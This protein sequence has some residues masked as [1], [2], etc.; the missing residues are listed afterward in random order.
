M[1]RVRFDD[2]RAA[3]SQRGCGVAAGRGKGQR[4]ITRAKDSHRTERPQHRPQAGTGL[5]LA[6][7]Q[8]G[9]NAR[10]H[11][12]PLLDQRCKEA[13]L[14]AGAAHFAAQPRHG[15]RCFKMGALGNGL[16]KRVQPIGNAPQQLAPGLSAG[17][18]EDRKRACRE[19]DS[20]LHFAG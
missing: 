13:K 7:R 9:V 16:L 2:D 17:A 12:G 4:K 8:C 10:V 3:G 6:I 14:A 11:P 15:Q 5:R 1:S 19:L 20:P 18:G